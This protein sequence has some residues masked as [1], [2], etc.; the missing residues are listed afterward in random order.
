MRSFLE[1]LKKNRFLFVVFGVNFAIAFLSLIFFIVKGGGVLTLTDDFNAQEIPFNMLANTAIK[2]GDVF[3]NW[4]IDIGSDFVETF[5]F[6][7]LGSPFFWITLLFPASVFPYL[8]G[9]VY[10]LKYAVAGLF[11]Y[12]YIHRFVKNKNT[13]LIG[14]M[15]YAFS[16]FQC[17]NLVFYHFHD[18]VALFPLLLI[19]LEK[20]QTEKK[21]GWFA[22]GIFVNALVNYIFFVGEA[23]FVI[24]YYIVRFMIP[25]YREY[26]DKKTW[27]RCE[28][29]KIGRCIA[30]GVLGVCMAGILFVPS[31]LSVLQNTRVS[32]H[33]TGS[34]ALTYNTVEF[35]TMLKGL[36]FPGESMK[37]QAAITYS[38]WYSV[39][40]YLPLAG[41]FLVLVYVLNKKKGWLSG[42]L[43][44]SLVMA[45]VPLLNNMFVMFQREYYRRW[46]YM[47]VLVMALASAMVLEKREEYRFK[48]PF[49]VTAG[50][51]AA[52]LVYM[53]V[54]PWEWSSQSQSGI[55]RTSVFAASMVLGFGGV[56][57]TAA[58]LKYA[59][60][61][62]MM[63]MTIAT[64]VFCCITT[65]YAVLLY[66]HDNSF[67][68][69]QATYDDIVKTGEGLDSD[70]LP[71]RY[72]IYD[73]YNNRNMAG[74]VPSRSSFNSTVHTS[75]FEFYDALGESRHT[76]SPQG[77]EGTNEILSVGYYVMADPWPDEVYQTFNN[78]YRDVYVYHDD[79]ALP[80]GFTYDTYM[81]KSEFHRI[82]N[83]SR[84]MAML[85]TLVVAD[86]D[87][88]TVSAFLRK[89]DAAADGA[90]SLDLREEIKAEHK[91]ESSKNFWYDSRSFGSTIDADSEKY[92][93]YSVPYSKS[94]S[95]SVN[96][97]EAEILN[98]NGLM[99]VRVSQGENEI[100]FSYCNKGLYA[101]MILSV[102]GFVGWIGYVVYNRKRKEGNQ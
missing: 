40:A 39:S 20:L 50:I 14:S 94:W 2:S 17:C 86:E 96:G 36:F 56:C 19:G 80:V 21:K 67:E 22:F 92:A 60:Q 83:G 101:G 59:R 65:V 23:I 48:K 31:I 54:Y 33:I 10:M 61:H 26:D 5:S 34:E 18:A 74:Y 13:A 24:L 70:I 15:M 84:A 58:I 81:T 25:Q 49:L 47:P 98:I 51:M 52:Y 69:A 100:T 30:E 55:F 3:W 76:L 66:R 102:L 7:N 37:S 91:Q 85:K 78:G 82:D 77:P 88:D 90:Y 27:L 16:G 68:S 12:L 97:Q 79:K 43:K 28:C 62:Y 45:L 87:E 8:T 64:A 99:A 35:L 41:M 32:E 42:M 29:K 71:Y 95:A 73:A 44:V 38:N 53:T 11:S 9:W 4:N 46:Y 57:L 63:V 6:Y 89:Y 93:F 72:M 1:K 75:I